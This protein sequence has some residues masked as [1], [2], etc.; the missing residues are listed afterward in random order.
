MKIIII[1]TIFVAA[2][3]LYDSVASFSLF[4]VRYFYELNKTGA[5]LYTDSFYKSLRDFQNINYIIFATI[6]FITALGLLYLFYH[7][8]I[9]LSS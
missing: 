9:R 2:T 5:F 6:D 1:L 8:E 4:I 7:L 3:N